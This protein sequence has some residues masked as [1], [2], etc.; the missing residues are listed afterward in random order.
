LGG[1]SPRVGVLDGGFIVTH[2]EGVD[3]KNNLAA[4][5]GDAGHVITVGSGRRLGDRHV[6]Q[7]GVFGLEGLVPSQVRLGD[8]APAVVVE[9]DLPNLEIGVSAMVGV[10]IVVGEITAAAVL[11]GFPAARADVLRVG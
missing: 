11:E 4:G 6:G 3:I 2:R 1:G 5:G 10:V 9:N 7:M 8:L